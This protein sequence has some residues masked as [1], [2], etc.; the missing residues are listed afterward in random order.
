MYWGSR[1]IATR[2][3]INDTRWKWVVSFTPRLL[4]ARRRSPLPGYPLST[5]LGGPQSHSGHGG[6]EKKSSCAGNRT[7]LSRPYPS[8]YT[9]W[10]TAIREKHRLIP[11]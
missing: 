11:S 8:H 3:L 10:A 2:I 4:Y 7:W 1:S 5:R 9:N 6:E